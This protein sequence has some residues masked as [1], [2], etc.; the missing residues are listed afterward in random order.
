MHF[1]DYAMRDRTRR[2]TPQR[3]NTFV[4]A[5]ATGMPGTQFAHTLAANTRIVMMSRTVSLV[6][7]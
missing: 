6:C 4:V 7:T 3:G 2:D 1:I 5:S